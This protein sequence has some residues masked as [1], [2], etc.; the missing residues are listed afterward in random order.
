MTGAAIVLVH[1][2]PLIRHQGNKCVP[3]VYPYSVL[4]SIYSV[5]YNTILIS[6][7]IKIKSRVDNYF[8]FVFLSYN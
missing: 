7:I 8:L 1:Y 3:G 5:T 2:M 6:H 4:K